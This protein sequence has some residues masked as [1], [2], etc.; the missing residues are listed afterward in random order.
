[1]LSIKS[2]TSKSKVTELI[3]MKYNSDNDSEASFPEWRV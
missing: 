2:Q 1:M 3:E